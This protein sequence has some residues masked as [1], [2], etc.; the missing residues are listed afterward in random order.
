MVSTSAFT[1]RSW[2]PLNRTFR[3]LGQ[4]IFLNYI[5]FGGLVIGLGK[6]FFPSEAEMMYWIGF[7]LIAA[8]PPGPSVIPFSGMLKGNMHYA[9]TSVLGGHIGALFLTPAIMLLFLGRSLVSPE[10]I[11]LIL[12]R[13]I[14]IPLILSRFLRHRKAIPVMDKYRNTF[15]KWGFLLIIMPIVGMSRDIIFSRPDVLLKISTVFAIVM[16]L[17]GFLYDR[18]MGKMGMDA[19]TVVSSTL[20]FVIKSS[21]FSGVVAIQ[22]FNE[23]TATP[24]AVLSIFV[25]LYVIFYSFF[26][27]WVDGPESTE[28]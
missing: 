26:R 4:S 3:I 1:F 28:P 18:L 17:I 22:F 15:V 6:L 2:F 21:A 12:L 9:V 8:A 23:E 16:F 5:L 19:S 13:L 10:A 25:T 11:S 14:V 27:K 20:G 7:V 24:S